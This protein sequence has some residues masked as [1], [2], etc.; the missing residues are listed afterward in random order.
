MEFQMV[1]VLGTRK[2]HGCVVFWHATHIIQIQADS[3]PISFCN[4]D[5]KIVEMPLS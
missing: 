2:E 3:I 4:F 1:V 5:T